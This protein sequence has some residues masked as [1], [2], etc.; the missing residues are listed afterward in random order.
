MTKK[1][2]TMLVEHPCTQD[3]MVVCDACLH[4]L[5]LE[6]DNTQRLKTHQAKIVE[7][8]A[9]VAEEQS[10]VWELRDLGT[11]EE[12]AETVQ[13][14]LEQ[15][16]AT[17][18][19]DEELMDTIVSQFTASR[20]STLDTR[21]LLARV[22]GTHTLACAAKDD[23]RERRRPGRKSGGDTLR[24]L[25]ALAK[26]DANSLTRLLTAAL[27]GI[28]PES[29]SVESKEV[30]KCVLQSLSISPAN[31]HHANVALALT[32]G[33]M[34]RLWSV[35]WRRSILNATPVASLGYARR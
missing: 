24:Q 34:W 28:V 22:L 26:S 13:S 18:T 23:R 30:R 20:G 35:P 25:K 10:K 4:K 17:S 33:R 15:L 29:A 2:A 16:L 5:K 8:E 14:L 21:T 11:S 31:P 7:L 1:T 9:R 6:R 27:E 19:N 3:H 12:P 32:Y